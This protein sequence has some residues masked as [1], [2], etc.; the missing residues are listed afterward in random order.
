MPV[1]ASVGESESVTGAEFEDPRPTMFLAGGGTG[2]HVFPAVAVA[3]ELETLGVRPVFI[4]TP[5]GL[6]GR[7]LPQR[8]F[9]LELLEVLPMTGGGALRFA[10]GAFA[11]QKAVRASLPLLARYQP[12]AVLSVG[13]YAAGPVS[14]A[15]A[16]RRIPVALLEPNG[17]L[18]F[19]NRVLQPVVKR[20]YV[21][22]EEM[23]P[24][25]GR[26]IGK[27]AGVPIRAVFSQRSVAAKTA[28]VRLDT[29]RESERPRPFRVLVLGGSQGAL[30]VNQRVPAALTRAAGGRTLTVT[31]QS[32]SRDFEMVRVE[33]KNLGF[34]VARVVEFLDDVAQ[35][36]A[37][38]DLIIARA[39]A[40]TVA[41]ICALGKPSVLLPF[42]H[43]AG[44][45]QAANARALERL[46]GCVCVLDKELE[47]E[48]LPILTRLIRDEAGRQRMADAAHAAG[49]P[50]AAR[51]IARDLI[52]LAGISPRELEEAS[53]AYA[54]A[55]QQASDRQ[56]T[57]VG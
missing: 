7:I 17:V 47:T 24:R 15:A 36:M 31:H 43:A 46:G 29:P 27:H 33:Y 52:E 25:F 19:A 21:G 51:T 1:D 3:E 13:G 6:E 44:D 2:G 23:I 5:R 50:D 28:S 16:L 41:E 26:G 57:E 20:A 53:R 35:E 14:L 18:G 30:R 34:E 12:R 55:S 56:A 54:G 4:G 48:L 49:K 9:E 40:S 39:G 10:S 8:G 32:G 22:W 37:R 45:H 38:A 42:P 11:A